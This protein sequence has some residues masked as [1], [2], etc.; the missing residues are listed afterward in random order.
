MSNKPQPA[1]LEYLHTQPIL[2]AKNNGITGEMSATGV[3]RDKN[4]KA[5]GSFLVQISGDRSTGIDPRHFITV[6]QEVLD[7]L[8]EELL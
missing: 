1:D 3:F 7:R 2:K 4:E 5:I 8:K 6:V